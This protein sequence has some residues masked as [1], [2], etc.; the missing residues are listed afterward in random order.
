MILKIAVKDWLFLDL[1]TSQIVL[2]GSITPCILVTSLLENFV[3]CT[4]PDSFITLYQRILAHLFICYLVFLGPIQFDRFLL[5]LNCSLRIKL[6]LIIWSNSYRTLL[7]QILLIEGI[8]VTIRG[9]QGLAD[10]RLMQ[11]ISNFIVASSYHR[12]DLLWLRRIV[13]FF[14]WMSK[15]WFFIAEG[16][17]LFFKLTFLKLM[18]LVFLETVLPGL[19]CLGTRKPFWSLW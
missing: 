7:S 11:S 8:T 2:E 13:F 15:I 4:L 10:R 14:D 12:L 6:G 3:Y 5:W 9:A 17:F 1:L 18:R 16:K 19:F